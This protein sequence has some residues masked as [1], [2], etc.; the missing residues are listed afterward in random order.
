MLSTILMT[1]KIE[2]NVEIYRKY[3][4]IAK[5]IEIYRKYTF[6]AKFIAH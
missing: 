2:N 4:F 6:I 5:F 1:H 3:T